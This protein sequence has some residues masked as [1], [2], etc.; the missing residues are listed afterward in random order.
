MNAVTKADDAY[1]SP[2]T[3]ETV[4]GSGDLSKLTVKQRVEYYGKVCATLGIN[5]M[6]RPFRFMTFQGQ[7]VLYATR[8]CA[9]QLRNLRNISVTITDKQL[10]GELFIVTAQAQTVTGRKDEDVGAVTLGQLRGEARANAIM[11]AMTKAK[12]R[13]TLSICG[14]GFLDE[15]E[16]ETLHGAATFDADAEPAP[17]ARI[18]TDQPTDRRAAINA[19]VPLDKP[20]PQTMGAWLNALEADLKD[21]MAAPDP[22][23][24]VDVILARDD[25]RKAHVSFPP[26]AKQRLREITEAALTSL[27]QADDDMDGAAEPDEVDHVADGGF[28]GDR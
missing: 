8:D 22:G 12:R 26:V 15:S 13:V 21:A 7:T 14:L 25:V 28:P 20:K 10:E 9:D 6:T 3:M 19:E 17:P 4:L 23:V 16:V 2:E 5:P 27:G 18:K 11:K 1:I 24:A